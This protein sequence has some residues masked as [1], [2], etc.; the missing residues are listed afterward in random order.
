MKPGIPRLLVITDTTLQTK[1]DHVELASRAID[2]GADGIQLRDKAASAR[3]LLAAVDATREVCARAGVP[4]LVNDRVDIALA[5]CADGAHVGQE[6]LPA[7]VARRLLGPNAIVGVTAY[8]P[9]MAR[10]ASADDA[11]YVGFG[12]VYGTQSKDGARPATGLSGLAEF[13]TGCAL[14]ILAIG[15]VQADNVHELLDAGA[16]GV[17]VISAVCC[18]PDVTA[19]ARA[20]SRVLA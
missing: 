18:A 7:E 6:D 10:A 1:Y 4:L 9:T 2:G 15:S 16:H 14:P 8:T 19:A 5:A 12:P 3:D 20:F 13:A 17:A 11:D